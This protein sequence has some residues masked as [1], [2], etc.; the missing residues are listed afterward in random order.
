[1]ADTPAKINRLLTNICSD[2][3]PASE[4]FYTQL[5]DFKAAFSSDWFVNLISEANGLELAIIAREHEIVPS[6]VRQQPTGFYLTL[7]VDDVDE[8]H[9]KAV[10]R[11]VEI[12][13]PPADTFYGQR[14]M[15]I[16]DPNGV[17]VDV[18]SPIA[19]FQF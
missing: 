1:M 5:F 15:L 2:D 11:D 12:I 16:R 8:F 17:V 14:R 13:Q 10:A 4:A 3:L 19:G 9:K 6:A 18:S 7:V